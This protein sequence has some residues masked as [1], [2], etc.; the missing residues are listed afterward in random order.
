MG[1]RFRGAGKKG[2]KQAV[3]HAAEI[4][5]VAGAEIGFTKVVLAVYVT[6]FRHAFH[7]VVEWWMSL[8]WQGGGSVSVLL[9]TGKIFARRG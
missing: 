9:E 2:Q 5:A 7:R 3:R 4:L 6:G 8:S 1:L